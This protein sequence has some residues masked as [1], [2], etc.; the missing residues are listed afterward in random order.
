MK[1]K[2]LISIF[3]CAA[4]LVTQAL[5]VYAENADNADN[6]EEVYLAEIR[7]KFKGMPAD[8]SQTAR[9]VELKVKQQKT[10]GALENMT[11]NV[12]Y[13]ANQ[14]VYL[15][16]T[17]E[18][19]LTVAEAYNATLVSYQYRVAT[20]LLSEGTTV[21]EA[22]AV[23]SEPA[24]NMPLVSANYITTFDDTE[25]RSPE[26]EEDFD[27]SAVSTVTKDSGY[28][29]IDYNDPAL[30]PRY[31]FYKKD[32]YDP[33]AEGTEKSG[34]QWMHSAIGTFEAWKTTTGS[35]DITVA[36][37][38]TGVNDQHEDLKGHSVNVTDAFDLVDLNGK[39]TEALDISGHGTH[40]AG[41]IGAT[42]NNGVGGAGIAPGV[43]I[44]G[45]PIFIG[46][47][48]GCYCLASAQMSALMYVAGAND[49]ATM[50]EPR[51]DII[52]LSIGGCNYNAYMQMIYDY[53]YSVG[54]TV[55]A[56]A[57]NDCSNA[58]EY[59]GGYDHVIT[60]AALNQDLSKTWFSNYG[61]HIDIAAPGMDI[62][63]TWNGHDDSEEE[64]AV[65]DHNDWYT[66]MNGTSQAT[67]VVAGACALYMS[68]VGHV[69]PDTMLTV[70]KKTATKLSDKTLGAGMVNA[71]AMMPD[72]SKD[73][74]LNIPVVSK[75]SADGK[76]KTVVGTSV[77]LEEGE[78]LCVDAPEGAIG[79]IAIFSVNGKDPAYKDGVVS[80]TS[81]FTAKLGT[82]IDPTE[83]TTSQS[84]KVKAAYVSPAGTRS[85]VVT[86]AVTV[87]KVLSGN[88]EI[89]GQAKIAAGKNATYK[90][91][92]TDNSRS[93]K[94]TW[95]LKGAPEGVAISKSGKVTVAA[96]VAAG[97]TF[98]VVATAADN[99]EITGSFDVTTS[100]ALTSMRLSFAGDALNESVNAPAFEK[101]GDYK[102][103]RMYTVDI[104]TTDFKE[105]ELIPTITTSAGATELSDY[106]VTSS[107]EKAVKYKD[108]KILAVGAGTAKLTFAMADG[109]KQKVTLSVTVIV[110]ASD[111]VLKT[112]NKQWILAPGGSI[113]LLGMLG[114]SYGKPT[115][116]TPEYEYDVWMR[117][118][119]Y[120]S[121]DEFVRYAWYNATDQFKK[122]NY[123][124]IAKNGKLTLKK[125]VGKFVD[126][127]F[128]THNWEFTSNGQTYTFDLPC[129]N[130]RAK[131]TDG[132]GYVSDYYT[133]YMPYWTYSK[134][135]NLTPNF[136][137]KNGNY[138][139]KIAGNKITVVPLPVD[140]NGY[141][142]STFTTQVRVKF[143]GL[144]FDDNETAY[145]FKSSDPSKATIIFD[146]Y[147]YDKD[148]AVFR[149]Y[150]YKP[151]SATL[152]I[153]AN[154]GI[155]KSIK[156]TIKS[157]AQKV[158][159]S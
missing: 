30:Y 84:F 96:T 77:T 88:I 140:E 79:D 113:Q 143:D 43:N 22:V 118:S 59:P 38:D 13:V 121:N 10:I 67:P 46:I 25:L 8:Y 94:V 32:A 99:E 152:T 87:N 139:S 141:F 21:A 153:S 83:Y 111:I 128:T 119:V 45:L 120:D 76:V 103:V 130:I 49:D 135:T 159:K 53:L 148:Y 89:T 44:L 149:V 52:N 107:N 142:E 144:V 31:R 37:I 26:I 82:A 6:T 157:S 66:L 70:L 2:R 16:D 123:V 138:E 124:T 151:G 137:D 85:K 54:V 158:K 100:A 97:K 125:T 50:G 136:I 3:L 68:A 110:P 134:I 20:A 61:S 92:R 4:M 47:Y 98:K 64:F 129:L 15:A 41:I 114:T 40:V 19:A 58:I 72:S 78:K 29:A 9:E 93:K 146:H 57:G 35:S 109:N 65:E 18:E 117:Y 39:P 23:G 69:D 132:T 74:A 48:G 51:A 63:S 133:V 75:I 108:G 156:I 14:I 42:L 28:V 86:V 56:A 155:G 60:V 5:P 115:I 55:V 81:T 27:Q 145:Q 127:Y 106:T 95:S 71:A 112:K 150:L 91:T 105:N 131:T 147:D 80:N 11:P 33:E 12:D 1:R 24:Y 73:N 116:S 17:K 7:T 90:A 102:S 126:D 104:G 154:D 122:G 36:V 34:Y 62:Y 101:N